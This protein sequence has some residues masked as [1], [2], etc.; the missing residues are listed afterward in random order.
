MAWYL[1]L[2]TP[3]GTPP[4]WLFAP[5]W[6]APLGTAPLGTIQLWTAPLWTAPLWIAPLWTVL[7]AAVGTAAWLVWRR[8]GAGEALRLWGWQIAANAFWTP[9]FFGLHQLAL[10]LVVN[11]VLLVLV[12]LTTRAFA[13][14]RPAAGWLMLPALGWTAYTAYLTAGFWWLNGV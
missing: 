1:S 7:Y 11:L 12:A 3:P 2:R 10:A 8:V 5:L 6:T 14:L 13:R 4:A 9:A